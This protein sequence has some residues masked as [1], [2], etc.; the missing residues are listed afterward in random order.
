MPQVYFLDNY[1]YEIGNTTVSVYKYDI[2]DQTYIKIDQFS[3]KQKLPRKY[4]DALKDIQAFSQH[5][6]ASRRNSLTGLESNFAD[7]KIAS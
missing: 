5:E 4:E 3:P 7:I 2:F 6:E 1:C